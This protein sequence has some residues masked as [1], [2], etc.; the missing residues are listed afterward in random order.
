MLWLYFIVFL[1][2][3]GFFK[4]ILPELREVKSTRSVQEEDDDMMDW[5]M[6]EADDDEF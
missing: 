1:F 2:V 5:L 3:M 4:D 6:Y